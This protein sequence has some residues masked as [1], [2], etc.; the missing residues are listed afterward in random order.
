[1][2]TKNIQYALRG[3]VSFFTLASMFF[4][5]VSF[6]PVAYAQEA[7]STVPNDNRASATAIGSLPYTSSISTVGAT[8]ESGEP[9]STCGSGNAATVWFK[10][11]PTATGNFEIDTLGSDYDTVLTVFKTSAGSQVNCNDNDNGQSGV[12]QSKLKFTGIK[13]NA[14]GA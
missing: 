4:A 3:L 6:I 13:G 9:V 11:T 8:L 2:H 5:S 14:Y 10:Y 7:A 12:A 1:M